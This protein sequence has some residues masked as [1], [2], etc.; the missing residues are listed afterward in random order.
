MLRFR[1]EDGSIFPATKEMPF[2]DVLEIKKNNTLSRECLNYDNGSVKNIHYGDVLIKFGDAINIKDSIVPYIDD[3]IELGNTD[4]CKNGDVVIADT[5]E[6]YAVGKV[7]EVMGCDESNVAVA[8]LHTFLCRPIF[9]FAKGFLGSYLNSFQYHS[10]LLPLAQGTKVYSVNKKS[11]Q[12]TYITV[13]SYEEQQKIADCLSSVDEL[14]SDYEYKLINM[15]NQKKGM[16]Q[17]FFSQAVRFK[18]AEEKAFP[19]WK[20]IKLGEILEEY[21]EKCSKG[22]EYEHVSLTKEGV[23][24]KTDRYERDFL[25]KDDNKLYRVTHV[26][27]ICYNPA[28]LKFGVI[29][30]NKYKD[31][32]F[33]PIYVTYRIREGYDPYFIETMLTRNDFI[34]YALKYQQGTV[35]ERMAV[36]SADLCSI[37]VNIPCIEEQQR[38]ADCLTAFDDTIDDLQKTVEHWK[39]V[40]KGLLQQLFDWEGIYDLTDERKEA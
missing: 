17:K 35:Y 10:Q 12:E 11:I 38:I 32:I 24:P 31:A 21:N 37:S 16:V 2:S 39:N 28:N 1:K 29:C 27:D 30:R 18:D 25:V 22:Q 33:S 4:I 13:P 3:S 15:Q 36:S 5:A 34:N 20:E 6:D 8:G 9:P 7:V 23:V 26:N 40:K 14:I 19:E